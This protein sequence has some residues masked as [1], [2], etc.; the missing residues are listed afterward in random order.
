V[1]RWCLGRM[2]FADRLVLGGNGLF[3]FLELSLENGKTRLQILPV[4]GIYELIV[5][6]AAAELNDIGDDPDRHP[7]CHTDDYQGHENAKRFHSE[8]RSA[9]R[10]EKSRR[11]SNTGRQIEQV[12]KL[13][14]DY[15]KVL[16]AG[17]SIR[18]QQRI[19]VTQLCKEKGRAVKHAL[20]ASVFTSLWFLHQLASRTLV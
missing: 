19:S 10:Y 7:D 8:F 9:P 12:A 11:N 14:P 20:L 2:N 17:A 18:G 1:N 16:S 5:L 4:F 6:C 13:F 3:Q 15:L